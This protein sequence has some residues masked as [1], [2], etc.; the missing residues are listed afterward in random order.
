MEHE[1]PLEKAPYAH[2]MDNNIQIYPEPR[3]Y[4]LPTTECEQME[5]DWF[6]KTP[7]TTAEINK[8]KHTH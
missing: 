4:G 6:G 3:H 8:E 7:T 5:M 1:N 2:P